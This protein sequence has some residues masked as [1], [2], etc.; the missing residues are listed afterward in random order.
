[1]HYGGVKDENPCFVEDSAHRIESNDPLVGKIRCY[2]FYAT[3]NMTTGSGGM[4]VTAD[5]EIY[6]RCR[7]FWR[8]GLSTSTADRLN[9]VQGYTVETMAGGYDGNDLAAAVGRVQLAKLPAFTERRNAVRDRY[10]QGLSQDW[11]GNH[12][13]PYFVKDEGEAYRMIEWMKGKGI[14]CGHHYPRTGWNGVSLPIYPLLTDEE[15]ET[16]ISACLEYAQ[17]VR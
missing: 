8:D 1:M 16:V 3:K 9:G 4:L 2:S 7:L 10:N 17:R 12:L 5:K 6:E 15:Q 14:M 11:Q 13:Y